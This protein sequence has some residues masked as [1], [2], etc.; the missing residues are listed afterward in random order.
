MP[1]SLGTLDIYIAWWWQEAMSRV[2]RLCNNGYSWM[3]T[4]LLWNSRILWRFKYEGQ[5]GNSFTFGWETSP[6]WGYGRRK[7]CKA[8]AS[9]PSIIKPFVLL[10][11]FMVLF[12][13][14]TFSWSGSSSLTWNQRTLLVGR[15]NC[16][17]CNSHSVWPSQVLSCICVDHSSNSSSF[18]VFENFQVCILYIPYIQVVDGFNFGSWDDACLAST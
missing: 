14:F 6:E 3:P 7:E 5:A 4:S 18:M 17:H 11:F 13:I 2:S 8:D 9:R 16:Y 10:Y 12:S 1:C 15:T